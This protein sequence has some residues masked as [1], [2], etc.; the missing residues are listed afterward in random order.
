MDTTGYNLYPGYACT[1][2]WHKSVT[3]RQLHFTAKWTIKHR[4]HAATYR[5]FN[6]RQTKVVQG[7]E[8]A[9]HVLG[10]LPNCTQAACTTNDYEPGLSGESVIGCVWVMRCRERTQL[11]CRIA[12]AMATGL[13]LTPPWVG[14]CLATVYGQVRS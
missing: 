12:V 10:Q 4:G 6:A 14:S 11:S 1:I 3:S 7:Q 2:T 5:S 8:W 13:R 9:W